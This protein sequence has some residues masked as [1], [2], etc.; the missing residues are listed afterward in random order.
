MAM[1]MTSLKAH[2]IS[3]HADGEPFRG[4]VTPGDPAPW[5]YWRK[6]MQ[7]SETGSHELQPRPRDQCGCYCWEWEDAARIKHQKKWSNV[8]DVTGLKILKVHIAENILKLQMKS[9]KN[10]CWRPA[11]HGEYRLQAT[12]FWPFD[13]RLSTLK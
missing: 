12:H 2:G 4:T 13:L 8:T 10:S 6:Q 3:W 11:S 7:R 1:S 9:A 5:R